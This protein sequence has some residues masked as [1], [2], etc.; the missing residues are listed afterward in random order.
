MALEP[1]PAFR[2]LSPACGYEGLEVAS[3]A[4]HG[5]AGGDDDP[6]IDVPGQFCKRARRELRVL[7]SAAWEDLT[8]DTLP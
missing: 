2:S 5:Q 8:D 6:G 3:S 1:G 7:V 4:L